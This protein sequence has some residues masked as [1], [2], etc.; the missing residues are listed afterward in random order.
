MEA[1]LKEIKE[2]DLAPLWEVY[3]DIV[4]REPARSEESMIW[5]WSEMLPLIEKSAELVQGNH[6]DHRVLILKNPKLEDKMATTTNILAA[7]QCVNPGEETAPHRHTP[8]ATR[9]IIEGSGGGTFVDGKRCEMF[10]GDLIITPNWTWHCHKNDNENRAIWLDVLDIPLVGSLDAV[11][12]D[13]QMGPDNH[14][15]KNISQI[16]DDSYS[17]GG[18]LPVTDVQSVKHSPRLRYS[19]SSSLTAV[20]NAP[21]LNDGSRSINY[22]NPINGA[23]ILPTHDAKIFSL[24]KNKR[25][26][27]TRTTANAVCI[28]IEGTGSSKIGNINLQWGAKDVFTIP[29]WSWTTHLASSDEAIIIEISD[30]QIMEKLNLYRRETQANQV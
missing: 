14:F 11:F 12:G 24:A 26:L 17:G 4:L 22:T 3:E 15:P 13:M 9:I 18:L 28:V 1:F 19:Y 6:A 30:R 29:H 20:R 2:H 23:G 5:R 25:T 10:E 7:F 8:A 21:K 16:P 27:K